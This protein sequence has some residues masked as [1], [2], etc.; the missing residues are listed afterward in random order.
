MRIAAAVLLV[1]AVSLAA[2]DRKRKSPK[3]PDLEVLET[4]ARRSE[5]RVAIDGRIR[6]SGEK[7][8]RRL[9]LL[10]DFLAPGRAVITTQKS[11]INEEIL[12]PGKESVF[13][14]ELNDPVRA[15]QY[16]IGGVDGA[17]RDLRVAKAGPFAIE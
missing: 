7:T 5:G 16:Q 6:N 3:P 10:F 14:V 11:P 12:E 1:L 17:G 15:V 8:I 13:R 9:V 4:S 2:A